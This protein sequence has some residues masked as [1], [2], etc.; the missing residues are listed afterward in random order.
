[1]MLRWIRVSA[2]LAMFACAAVALAISLPTT[3]IA[4]LCA[5]AEDQAHCGRLIEEIQLKRLPGL[6]IRDGD[7]LKVSLFPS[8][9]TTFHDSIALSGAKSFT[10]WE[11]FDRINAVVLFT[12]DGDQTGFLVLQRANGKQYRMPSDPVLSPD[13]QRL[14]TVDI[15]AKICTGE[16]AVWRV[17]RD[18]VVKELTWKPQPAWGDASATWVDVDTLR[19]DYTMGGDEHRKQD[20][21]LGDA[22]WTRARP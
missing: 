6:A 10:L 11:Y 22:V 3:Q 9:T 20:R 5:N 7:D 13:R 21:R 8:G 15:C 2:A 17:T 14:V 1:M 12:T 18:D 16:V 4:E 19:F